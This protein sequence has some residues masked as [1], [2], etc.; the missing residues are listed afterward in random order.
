[1][2]E[3][4]HTESLQNGT[5]E[6]INER[7]YP[8]SIHIHMNRPNGTTTKHTHQV[9]I[10]EH[11]TDPLETTSNTFCPPGNPMSYINVIDIDNSIE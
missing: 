7:T 9:Y 2:G 6:Y 10:Y 4:I 8:S 3:K 11:Q 1:M 5:P